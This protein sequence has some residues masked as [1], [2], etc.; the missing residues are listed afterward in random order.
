MEIEGRVGLGGDIQMTVK[1][2][3][4][5]R[6]KKRIKE[7]REEKVSTRREADV[8]IIHTKEQSSYQ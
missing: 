5:R 3:K 1:K 7:A 8:A 4:K 6:R 2:R